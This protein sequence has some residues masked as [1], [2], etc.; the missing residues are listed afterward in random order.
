MLYMLMVGLGQEY[1]A[2]F[3]RDLG[4]GDA[5]VGWLEPVAM[6][7]ATVVQQFSLMM[8]LAAGSYKRVV[9]IS[10]AVQ[11][12]LLV[13]L[14]ALAWW[15]ADKP[16]LG[17]IPASS[18]LTIGVFAL[19]TAY[20]IGA[21]AGSPP[22][23]AMVGLAIPQRVLPRYFGRRTVFIHVPLLIGLLGGLAAIHHAAS[24]GPGDVMRTLAV[25]FALSAVARGGSAYYLS[26]YSQ[27]GYEPPVVVPPMEVIRRAR[28][29]NDGRALTYL[30][31]AQAAMWI[32][33]PFFKPY[34]LSQIG[35]S[36]P[37]RPDD[38]VLYSS[39]LAAFFVGKMIAPE[40][41]GRAIHRFGL[42]P[43]TWACA[44]A[45]VPVPIAWLASDAFWWLIAFQF[46][47][48]ASLGTFELCA[49]LFQMEH[50]PVRERTSVLSTFG[51][52]LYAAGF[53]G[54]LIGGLMLGTNAT[55]EQY[56]AIFWLSAGAR[57][58]SL[59]LLARLTVLTTPRG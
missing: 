50:V 3:A 30:I 10:A 54:S 6:L 12:S 36:S 45:L 37:D 53:A 31:V 46:A 18:A 1:I 35:A 49:L 8:V 34:M 22:W 19:V 20:Y 59:L 26:R 28:S 41:A 57:L 17:T 4:L 38:I 21:F 48:G 39:L 56:A 51:L 13:P 47:S 23:M 24:A 14:S 16:D 55:T 2:K 32:A 29:G 11:A 44:I 58:L 52:G 25:M 33:F 15:A 27:H 9:W 42:L 7:I 40:I 43:V 5:A